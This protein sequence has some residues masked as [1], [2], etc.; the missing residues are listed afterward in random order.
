MVAPAMK[1]QKTLDVRILFNPID[2]R[3]LG[4]IKEALGDMKSGEILEVL[5]NGFQHR[6]IEAWT[7]KF[8]HRVV[9]AVNE[10]GLVRMYIEKGNASA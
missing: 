2:C 1:A 4:V 6:E 3:S 5:G 8:N 10:E 9:E 7:R